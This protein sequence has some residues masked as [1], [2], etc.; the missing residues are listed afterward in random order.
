MDPTEDSAGAEGVVSS[1]PESRGRFI[2]GNSLSSSLSAVRSIGKLETV[3][4]RVAE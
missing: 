3:R 2:A 4:F 1:R